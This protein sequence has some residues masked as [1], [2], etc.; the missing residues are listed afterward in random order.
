MCI[1]HYDYSEPLIEGLCNNTNTGERFITT[2]E[3]N[4]K[5]L[6]Y[7]NDLCFDNHCVNTFNCTDSEEGINETVKGEV[8]F[9]QID[10]DGEKTA[11]LTDTCY[12]DREV[13][14]YYC[15]NGKPKHTIRLCPE[16][17]GL[18]RNGICVNS[19]Y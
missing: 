10:P 17:I 19:T 16:G 14:E 1:H 9:L 2:R 6:P 3:V 4:C 5:M 12:W 8:K 11:R 13:L 18:C 15:F 7:F